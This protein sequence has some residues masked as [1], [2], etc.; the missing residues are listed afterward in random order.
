MTDKDKSTGMKSAY[1]RAL[2]RLDEDGIERPREGGLDEEV[3]NEIAEIR[4]RTEAGIAKLEILLRDRL[5]T[6]HDPVERATAQREYAIDRKR[7]EEQCDH[8][9]EKLRSAT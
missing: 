5:R 6:L 8:K 9:I 4:S 1:E 3:R 7:L 2:E